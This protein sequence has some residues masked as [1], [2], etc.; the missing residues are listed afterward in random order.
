MK[1]WGSALFPL[2]ILLALTLLTFWLRYAT[3]LAE[4]SRDG[5]HRHDPDYIVSDIVLRKL[6]LN[7]QLKYTLKA[8]DVR[9]YPDDDTMDL[10]KPNI[11]Y[12]Y[13]TKPSVTVDAERGHVSRD[14]KGTG[15]QVDLLGDVRIHRPAHGKYQELTATMD[16]LTAFPDE[17]TAFTKSPVVINQGKSWLKGVGMQ[18]NHRTQTY[19]LESQ[20]SGFMESK[21]TRKKAP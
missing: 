16:E 12:R 7:G 11:V 21:Q 9:H 6:D 8:A 19:V 5:K 17:E 20:V 14:K 2:S 1:H 3:E 4:P 10:L 18:V 13:P 15:D